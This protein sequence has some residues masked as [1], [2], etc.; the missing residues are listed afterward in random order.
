MKRMDLQRLCKVSV[1]SNRV[2][3]RMFISDKEYGVK[4]NLKTEDLIDLLLDSQYSRYLCS[5]L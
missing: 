4:A 1:Y 2:Q 3:L 5:F